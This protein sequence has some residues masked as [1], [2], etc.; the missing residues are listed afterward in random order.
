MNYYRVSVQ[1]VEENQAYIPKDWPC[2]Q[3]IMLAGGMRCNHEALSHEKM[4][5]TS[6]LEIVLD[7][8]EYQAIKR[9]VLELHK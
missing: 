2:E 6:T 7:E 8:N 4:I 5:S 3:G 1:K 9:A